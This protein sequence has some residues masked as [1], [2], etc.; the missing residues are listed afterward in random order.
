MGYRYRSSQTV[1]IIRTQALPSKEC[2]SLNEDVWTL[3]N[4]A[5]ASASKL[6]DVHPVHFATRMYHKRGENEQ[7]KIIEH[8]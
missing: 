5:A 8:P 1:N 4:S 2:F 6:L 7:W 3:F